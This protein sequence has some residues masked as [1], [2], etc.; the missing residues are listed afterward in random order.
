M[1]RIFKCSYVFQLRNR[2]SIKYVRN[3]GNKG[4]LSKTFTGAYRGRG[5]S[6]LMCKYALTLSLSCFCLMVSCFIC[7][8]LTL[9]LFKKSVFVRNGHSPIR[10]ISGVMK[11]AFFT[12]NSFSERKLAKTVLILIK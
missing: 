8:S 11:S 9:P 10:S 1:N 5:I 4:G 3:K 7:R 6:L 2:T 12:L